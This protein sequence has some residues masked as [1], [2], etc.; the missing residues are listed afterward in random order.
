M[1][2][3][4]ASIGGSAD[5]KHFPV[6]SNKP[7][8]RSRNY[9]IRAAA[10]RYANNAELYH[11]S[12]PRSPSLF[13]QIAAIDK[14]ESGTGAKPQN[15]RTELE[16]V[17]R[18]ELPVASRPGRSRCRRGQHAWLDDEEG[19]RDLAKANI[20]LPSDHGRLVRRP[21][22]E[23]ED[24]FR[25]ATTAKGNVRLRRA[26]NTIASDEDAQVAELYSMGLLYDDDEQSR[27][28]AFNLNSIK[29]DETLYTIR[30]SKRA[31]KNRTRGSDEPLHLDLSFADLGNDNAI[32]Q[33]LMSPSAAE[34]STEGEASHQSQHGSRADVPLR[35]IYELAT[36]TP[37]YDV[38]TS[39]PPDLINDSLSDYDCLSESEFD[40]TPSQQE[41]YDTAANPPTEA[42]IM[43]GD[44]S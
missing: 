24:A 37:S 40:D 38:D 39:Q 30:P 26:V 18:Q 44:D 25:D 13:E 10:K 8:R 28:E 19:G 32:A 33:Y 17:L 4:S 3:L 2:V 22:L 27:T 11:G 23:R 20:P 12:Q 34:P 7:A 6:R 9:I 21:S 5:Y 36:S 31:R 42:W 41:V 29:H 35:V 15:R 14:L 1:D 16:K 43:L